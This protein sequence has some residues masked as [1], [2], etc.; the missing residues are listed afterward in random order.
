MT[1]PAGSLEQRLTDVEAGL[2]S[3]MTGNWTERASVVNAEG[4]AVPLSQLAFGM[5][6]STDLGLTEINVGIPGGPGSAGWFYGTPRL[7]V[8]VNGGRLLV[9]TA[10]ALVAS[11][12]KA[13]MFQSYRLIGPTVTAGAVTTVMPV[14]VGPAYDRAVEVQ[15]SHSGMDQ[16]GAAGTFGLHTGLAPGWYRIESAYAMSYSGG[17][18]T[19]GSATNRRIAA[20]P[21]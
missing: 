20:L 9:L 1:A 14:A 11:G 15:H 21:Y 3:L 18:P 16:R 4:L 10:A 8:L 13:S 5:A 19:Y 2:R 12:N 6:A 17:M 7:D